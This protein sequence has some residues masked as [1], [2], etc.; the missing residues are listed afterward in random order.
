M[1]FY[2][3]CEGFMFFLSVHVIFIIQIFLVLYIEDKESQEGNIILLLHKISFYL[4]LFLTFY[5]HLKIA[6][7]DP[8]SIDYYNNLDIIEFY[9]FIYRDIN[10]IK[11]NSKHINKSEIE[12][13]EDSEEYEDNYNPQSDEDNK[14]FESKTSISRKIEKEIQKKFHIITTRCYN[15]HVVRPNNA[16][17][18]TSCHS[19]ILDRDHHCPWMNNCIGIFNKKY[20]ILFNI[21]AFISVIYSSFLFYYYTAYKNNKSFRNDV[22]KN[23]IGIFWGLFAFIYGL[24][25]AIMTME[26]RDNVL[27]EFAR[28]NK[29]KEKKRKLMGIKMRIIF[30]GEFS[31]KW[32]LPFYEG[33]KRQLFYFIRKKK[34][35]MYQ[36]K[37]KEKQNNKE[38]INDIG[39]SEKANIIKEKS[40]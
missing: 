30:G 23:L 34:Y 13:E 6:I 15:C 28:Y 24:F 10:L 40:E 7:T 26:Q 8:G 22:A 5:S 11:E 29:N 4:I 19:C 14:K 36:Q 25:V 27:K 9:Y 1:G 17:H 32:F 31:F 3:D 20:F 35:E 21:Y 33:G 37:L 18:C 38:I 12:E 39:N 2:K 16:H